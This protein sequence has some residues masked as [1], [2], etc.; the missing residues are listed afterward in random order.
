MSTS[1]FARLE[2]LAE[3]DTLLAGLREWTDRAPD[4]PPARQCQA[5]VRRLTERMDALR[6]RWEA[7]LV[8]ALLGGTGTGKSTLVN[9]LVGD[10]VTAV[11]RERPT[12][13]VPT[14]V[15]RP[16]YWPAD[17]G[18]RPDRVRVVHRDLPTLRDWVLL[19]CPDP[20]TTEEEPGG[21]AAAAEQVTSPPARR[22]DASTL[23][24]TSTLAA[25]TN[26][27]RLRELLPQCDV[28]IVTTTQQKYRSARVNEELA[29]AARGARLIFVQ[30]HADTDEDIRHDW[31]KV[32]CG[33]QVGWAP[34]TKAP[35]NTSLVGDA[36][37]TAL[38]GGAHP[39]MGDR[40]PAA[41]EMFF[42]DSPAAL[43]DARA[44]VAPRGEFARLVELLSREL[45]GSAAHRIRRANFL[46]LADQTL[47]ACQG[48]LAGALPAIDRLE[49]AIADQRA[50]LA[51]RAAAELRRELLTSRRHWEN[52]LLGEVAGRWGFSPFSLV[53]RAYQGLGGLI[54]STTLFRMRSPAQLAIW[55]AL[56]GA[57]RL[58]D[59]RERDAAEQVWARAAAWG[60]DESELRSAG[61]IVD[62]FAA[63]AGLP[64]G[65]LHGD[66]LA[67]QANRSGADFVQA[68]G[69][70]LQGVISRL[71]ARQAAWWKRWAYELALLAML[72]AILFRLGKNYFY[73]SW[74][75]P[76]VF[77][78]TT[79]AQV[80]GMD[81][82]IQSG[83]W[84]LLW[85]LLLLWL[86][87]AR[88]RR[89]LGGA[90]DELAGRWTREAP[91][92]G[93]FAGTERQCQ[94]VR[95][96]SDDCQRLQAK[97]NMARRQIE[98][99]RGT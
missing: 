95:Q 7:P 65:E 61:L 29:A 98:A 87:T 92:P 64:R 55:G 14:L 96:F 21:T 18:I 94:I 80:H 16:D 30:T 24:E 28:L 1:Q 5:L 31:C 90:I 38:V 71:A 78:A 41:G 50:R 93:L 34:P 73:D 51:G 22:A 15:C 48:K 37:H 39:T 66:A 91:L 67:A 84:L 83:F 99:P 72:G 32:L 57:R 2:L 25:D 69:T 58:R 49:A 35:P 68:A 97:L 79:P 56:E 53:L 8:V 77:G 85:C 40:H 27:A 46:D 63:E 36:H 74:L 10:E 60:W 44:G 43:A 9:A 70:G 76:E 12:T 20:D 86:F 82:F 52:R 33:D 47:A 45:A 19:D 23:A 42:V 89:G 4:W 81:F 11:G 75:G 59:R 13:R 3:L 6:V 62:G 26:L 17:F 54:A 88:L